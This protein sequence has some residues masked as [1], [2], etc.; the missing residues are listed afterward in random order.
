MRPA[1]YATSSAAPFIQTMQQLY[2]KPSNDKLLN[3]LYCVL[4]RCLRAFAAL[5]VLATI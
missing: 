1:M 4:D 3:N 5:H 2:L